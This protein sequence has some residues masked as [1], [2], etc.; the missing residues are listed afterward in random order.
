MTWKRSF[1]V[2]VALFTILLTLACG[3]ASD[4]TV[5]S[6][7]EPAPQAE[8]PPVIPATEDAL[9]QPTSSPGA[10]EQAT[11]PAAQAKPAAGAAVQQPVVAAQPAAA[12]SEPAMPEPNAANEKPAPTVPSETASATP[13]AQEPT[14]GPEPTTAPPL[15]TIEEQEAVRAKIAGD[16]GCDNRTI[17]AIRQSCQ[18]SINTDETG[19]ITGVK[20]YTRKEAQIPVEFAD[21]PYLKTLHLEKRRHLDFNFTGPI[22]EELGHLE[23]ITIHS[24]IEGLCTPTS[25]RHIL[26]GP[27]TSLQLPTCGP[28]IS[29]L[30][31][32]IALNAVY[33]KMGITVDDRQRHELYD[34]PGVQGVDDRGHIIELSLYTDQDETGT[35]GTFPEEI[36][37]FIY[38]ESLS[39]RGLNL[40]GE[41]SGPALAKLQ[42][43]TYLGI[44]WANFSGPIPP[45]IGQLSLLRHLRI[46][47]SAFR[48]PIPQELAQLDNLSRLRIEH[49]Q[50]DGEIP[51]ALGELAATTIQLNDNQLTGQIPA[52]VLEANVVSLLLANNQLSGPLPE[53]GEHQ[54]GIGSLDLS[55]NQL[56]GPIPAS[57]GNLKG[58]EYLNLS[59]NNLTGPIPASISNLKGLAGLSLA[60]NQLEGPIPASI[61]NMEGLRGLDLSGN[62]LTGPIPTALGDMNLGGLN[63]RNNFLEGPVP[64]ELANLE[65]LNNLDLYGNNLTGE[66]PL[67]VVALDTLESITFG[68]NNGLCIPQEVKNAASNKRIDG[69]IC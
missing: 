60:D 68:E 59:N 65:Q 38:L 21:L 18:W 52:E 43:L 49:T 30:E 62:N 28:E 13:D 61:S 25:M 26:S 17:E 37:D 47:Y 3:A 54:E 7:A 44:R 42:N 2:T 8:Q 22:P 4:G 56:H 23:T 63:L 41:L 33:E 16:L 27:P 48:G 5:L 64:E 45:E 69:P 34:Y 50:L 20:L 51:S 10:Q 40:T 11:T 67:K 31:Q 29:E 58:L 24:G 19:N 36:G 1:I 66:I 32:I 55:G 46:E 9:T 39:M 35:P 15:A 53:I 12:K 6:P 14:A 57:I